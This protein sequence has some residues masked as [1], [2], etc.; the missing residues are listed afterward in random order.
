MA[1]NTQNT[2]SPVDDAEEPSTV[3][4]DSG[5]TNA[6]KK[7][8]LNTSAELNAGTGEPTV[9][10]LYLVLSLDRPMSPFAVDKGL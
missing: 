8:K 7:R 6:V 5:R 4:A 2:T 9:S 1:T 3:E 10:P